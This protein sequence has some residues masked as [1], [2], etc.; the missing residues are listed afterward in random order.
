MSTS[1]LVKKQS[2]FLNG[3]QAGIS[4][5][6]GYMPIALTFGILAK[7][8]GLS[9][10]E[11]T[12]MSILVFAGA[13]QYIS[14]S[15]LAAYT[16]LFEIILT[17]FILNLRHFLMSASLSEK[18]ENDPVWKK[19]VYSFGLTDETFSVAST[20]EGT[21]NAGYMFGLV[22]ISYGSWVVNSA[23]GYAVGD[24]L[25]VSVQESMGIALYAM[26]IGLLVPS[27][28]K[29]RKVV[30]LASLAAVLNSIFTFSAMLPAGWSIIVS[31][32]AASVLIE[33]VQYWRKKGGSHHE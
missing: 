23:A 19:A 20:K 5:A 24:I 28:K 15:L 3:M 12:L 16:G 30:L 32:V 4:I 33:A 31:T 13:A 9:I 14:L 29:H 11:T 6:V 25:P 26:F 22:L 27:L 10:G 21:V 18:A 17:T 1:V 2:D 7:S 8:T